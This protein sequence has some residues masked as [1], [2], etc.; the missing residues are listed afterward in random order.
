M[1]IVLKYLYSNIGL[2]FSFITSIYTENTFFIYYFSKLIIVIDYKWWKVKHLYKNAY[3]NVF[4]LVL[5]F[6]KVYIFQCVQCIKENVNVSLNLSGLILKNTDLAH[7]I[8]NV[9]TKRCV[10]F[11]MLI[12]KLNWNY[13]QTALMIT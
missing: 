10:I 11:Q 7:Q 5:Q 4:L 8:L 9:K 3:C 2:R 1:F 6:F 12:L 13:I